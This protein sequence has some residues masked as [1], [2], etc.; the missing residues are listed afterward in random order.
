MGIVDDGETVEVVVEIGELLLLFL[1][2]VGE[3]EGLE[4]FFLTQHYLQ[5]VLEGDQLGEVQG[6]ELVN[7]ACEDSQVVLGNEGY[8][9]VLNMGSG[10]FGFL[11]VHRCREVV[12]L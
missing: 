2:H 4:G 8:G 1:V 10:G 3:F 12:Q 9:G 11:E 6:L 7:A 5:L